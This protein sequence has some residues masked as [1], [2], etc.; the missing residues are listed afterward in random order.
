MGGA[1]SPE[2][3][4][5]RHSGHEWGYVISGEL[6]VTIGFDDYILE[7]GDAVSLESTTPHRLA[8]V[9][10]TPV[11]AIWFVLGRD[12]YD[13]QRREGAAEPQ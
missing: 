9:G 13:A 2:N 11:H 12:P 3:A 1:S 5:Q 7:P 10:D 6:K 8:N 4:Y